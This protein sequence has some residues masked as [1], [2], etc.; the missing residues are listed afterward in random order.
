MDLREAVKIQLEFSKS[1]FPNFWRVE[2]EKDVALRLEY[3]SNALA[4]EV[5]EL[6]NLVK[7]VV[8]GVVYGHGG[9]TLEA[10]R[11]SIVEELTDV[12]IYTLT[13]AGFLGVDLE[14]AFLK[15]LEVNR[16]RF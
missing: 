12:F 10:L 2:D 7:K 6:A 9:A 5:G 8:R 16:S 4:G 15:K 13:M 14:E 1:K 11:E 3:L